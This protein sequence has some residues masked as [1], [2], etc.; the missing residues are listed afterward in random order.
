M[1]T[2]TS[3][4]A[5]TAGA[6]SANDIVG[7]KITLAG[8]LN[9]A[10]V[11]VFVSILDKGGQSAKTDFFFFNADLV[12]TYTD[13]APFSIDATDMS[14]LIGSITVNTADYIAVGSDS[15][16]TTLSLGIPLQSTDGSLY[17][18]AV[19]R[20]TPTYTSTSDLVLRFSTNP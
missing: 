1:A 6:Y 10:S 16:A 4:P 8:A 11:L 20:G 14:K 13:N 19:T 7:G 15:L 17:V 18:L 2:Y 5:I 9:Q 12:G 3:T